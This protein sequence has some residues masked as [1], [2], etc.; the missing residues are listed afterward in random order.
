MFLIYDE[1][2]WQRLAWP[3]SGGVIFILASL[4]LCLFSL[5]GLLAIWGGLGRPHWF[6]RAVV[7]LGGLSLWLFV[8]AYEPMLVFFAQT[9][10]A[11]LLLSSGKCWRGRT[12]PRRF[13]QFSLRDMLLWTV[14]VAA[15]SAAAAQVTRDV[16]HGWWKYLLHGTAYGLLT[17][18]A[19]WVALDV[20]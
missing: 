12:Q 5:T 8:P 15:V 16:W 6:V 19:A 7:V 4:E 18:A 10:V 9:A 1:F 2:F 14:V 20:A 11:S 17:V 13:P 3:H